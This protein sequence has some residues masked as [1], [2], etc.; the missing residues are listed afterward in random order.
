MDGFK[1]GGQPSGAPMAMSDKPNEEPITS[2]EVV[3][4]S[5]TDDD[6]TLA[7]K[8]KRSRWWLKRLALIVTVLT[9]ATVG[10]GYGWYQYQLTAVNSTDTSV[11]RVEIKEGSTAAETAK[12]LKTSGL[13]RSELAFDIYTRV[14][15]TRSKLQ[16]GTCKL[17]PAESVESIVNKLT[18]GCVDFKSILFY[19]GATLTDIVAKPTKQ[20]VTSVLLRAGYSLADISTAFNKTYSGPLFADKPPLADLEGYVYGET[21]YV[22]GTATV[23]QVLQRTFDE[24]YAVIEQNDLIPAFKKHGLNLYQAITLASIIQRE[25]RS[26]ADMRQVAQVFF[27][28]LDEHTSLGS[29]PTS[30]YA[31]HKLNVLPSTTIDSPYNTRI[32]QGLPPGPIASPGISALKAVASPAEGDYLFFLSGD[33]GKTYFARTQAEHE[34]NIVNYCQKLCSEL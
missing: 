2:P 30:I 16:A 15:G 17:T 22:D 20:D 18:A 21:Y 34:S 27:K 1:R 11:H 33:D 4:P 6:A 23:E 29:D 7:P 25:V 14:S 32:H 8:Q 26:E 10:I 3:E 9:L 31:A 24:M 13:I 5:A 19:P 28:R 12:L